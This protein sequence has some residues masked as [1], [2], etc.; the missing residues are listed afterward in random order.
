MFSLKY[1][2]EI[3]SEQNV[4]DNFMQ[5]N[6]NSLLCNRDKIPLFYDKFK[7]LVHGLIYKKSKSFFEIKIISFP[8]LTLFPD[9]Q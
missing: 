3:Y 7:D 5:E 9:L 8:F 6:L 4:L 2:V 1:L